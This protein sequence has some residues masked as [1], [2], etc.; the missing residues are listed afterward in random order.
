MRPGLLCIALLAV[1]ACDRRPPA[2]ILCHNANCAGGTNPFEDANLTSL[3]RSLGMRYRGKPAASGMELDTVWDAANSRCLFAHDFEHATGALGSEAADRVAT[4]LARPTDFVSWEGSSYFV[5]IELKDTVSA[6]GDFHTA[7]DLARHYDCVFDMYTRIAAA[8]VANH[9]ELEIAFESTAELVRGL[10]SHPSWPGKEPQRGVHVRL[11]ANVETPGLRP[12]DLASLR[13]NSARDGLD[14]LSFHASRIPDGI[15]QSYLA[16]EV[17]VMIWM[18][19]TQP[20]TYYAIEAFQPDY[21][22]TNEAVLIRR[23]LED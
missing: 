21:I 3:D 18:L 22:D 23:W 14:I 10:T 11:I 6:S 2:I 9:R 15:L 7:D 4:Y 5:K 19:D 8:A 17:R 16:L 12:E 13:G 20:E 1:T